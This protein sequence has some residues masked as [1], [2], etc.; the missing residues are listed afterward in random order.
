M[1]AYVGHAVYKG[2]MLHV[3]LSNWDLFNLDETLMDLASDGRVVHGFLN[4][5]RIS[6]QEELH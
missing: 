5:N 4:C 3:I 6:D 1:I 2:E